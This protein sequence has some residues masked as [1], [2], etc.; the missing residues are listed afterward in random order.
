MA[1]PVPREAHTPRSVRTDEPHRRRRR[2]KKKHRLSIPAWLVFYVTAGLGA[3]GAGL[4]YL[5]GEAYLPFAIAGCLLIGLT[6]V[7]DERMGF[8]RSKQ[9]RR[10]GERRVNFTKVEIMILFVLLLLNIYVSIHV[11]SVD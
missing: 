9:L 5:R 3:A 6:L 10:S 7:I 4:A 11:W 2:R 1:V 8:T